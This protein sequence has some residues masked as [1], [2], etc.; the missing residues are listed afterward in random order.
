[1][2]GRMSDA[3]HDVPGDNEN[4]T[5]EKS[6]EGVKRETFSLFSCYH[7]LFSIKYRLRERRFNRY[8]LRSLIEDVFPREDISR[9]A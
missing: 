8:L 7:I 4:A 3:A 1:M 6:S 2:K 9:E 5:F